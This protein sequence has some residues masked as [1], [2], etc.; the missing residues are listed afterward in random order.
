MANMRAMEFINSKMERST[1]ECGRMA[2]K[3]DKEF[4]PTPLDASMMVIGSTAKDLV[5]VGK[6]IPMEIYMKVSI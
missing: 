4:L 3:M 1:K 2:S 5:T 6:F